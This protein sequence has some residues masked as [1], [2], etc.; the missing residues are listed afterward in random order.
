MAATSNMSI[1]KHLRLSLYFLT[2][3]IYLSDFILDL[4]TKIR[5]NWR[6]CEQNKKK[7]L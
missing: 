7:A 3:F 1:E 2:H 4:I 5:S 6:R